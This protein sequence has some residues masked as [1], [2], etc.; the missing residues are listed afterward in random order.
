MKTAHNMRTWLFIILL[1]AL[2]FVAFGGGNGTVILLGLGF[3]ACAF[4]TKIIKDIRLQCV[5]SFIIALFCF[6]IWM[7]VTCIWTLDPL[8]ALSTA[9]RFSAVCFMGILAYLGLKNLPVGKFGLL[10]RIFW[11]GI[12][13]FL[14]LLCFENLSKNMIMEMLGKDERSFGRPSILFALFFLPMLYGILGEEKVAS[15]RQKGMILPLLIGLV[16]LG[17]LWY[18]PVR[19]SFTA[20]TGS[21]L[22]Y[23]F[24]KK[25]PRGVLFFGGF[26]TILA[27]LLPLIFLYFDLHRVD[28]DL[29]ARIP[30]SWQHRLNIWHFVSEQIWAKPF[31]GWGLD[32]SRWMPG[33][34][35]TF[36][37]YYIE[38]GKVIEGIDRGL[39][40]LHPHS[41]FL[42]LWLEVGVVG[43]LLF[44]WVFWSII[45]KIY[46]AKIDR[47]KQAAI[48]ACIFMCTL[49]ASTSFGIWQKWWVSSFFLLA[50]VWKIIVLRD[51]KKFPNT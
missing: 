10:S 15:L 25:F 51:L 20:L 46:D 31:L 21:I 11:I 13:G 49:V 36:P 5:P 32:A 33:A 35:G 34:D 38:G 22:A 27:L 28:P 17:V 26:V 39:L 23:F 44:L 24:F 37:Y 14:A 43:I 50:I 3:F 8:P 18:M 1:A 30:S 9:V 2:P 12:L 48:M 41:I 47:D 29:L 45:A 7:F 19:A 40:P 42:H 16:S 6:L 4:P